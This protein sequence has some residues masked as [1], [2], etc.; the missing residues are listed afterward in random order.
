MG[1]GVTTP[2]GSKA[3]SC[4]TFCDLR[5][6]MFGGFA[7]SKQK[8]K[9][10][11]SWSWLYFTAEA[12]REKALVNPKGRLNKHWSIPFRGFYWREWGL[13]LKTET[14]L[15]LCAGNEDMRAVGFE[16][17]TFSSAKFQVQNCSS[18]FYYFRERSCK[19]RW[20]YLKKLQY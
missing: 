9:N 14:A 15:C 5:I 10:Q 12:W 8:V 11:R 7:M 4:P 6:E 13:G 19:D 2:F 3:K 18:R 17:K 1:V 20:K 16:E